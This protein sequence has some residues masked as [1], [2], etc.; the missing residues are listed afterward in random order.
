ML[1]SAR[2]CTV[3]CS[4]RRLVKD[5]LVAVAVFLDLTLHCHAVD[6]DLSISVALGGFVTVLPVNFTCIG[7]TSRFERRI[8]LGVSVDLRSGNHGMSF[9]NSSF[10]LHFIL[11]TSYF[12]LHGRTSDRIRSIVRQ[13]G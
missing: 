4:Q 1:L 2:A 9:Y 12:I 6:Q 13:L 7:Q 11:H 3:A 10:D 5:E 8:I